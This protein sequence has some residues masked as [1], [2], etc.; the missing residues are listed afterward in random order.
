[1]SIAI[2]D[3][4]YSVDGVSLL[5]NISLEVESG[6]IVAIVGPNGSGKSSLLKAA[7]GE[8]A[9]Q[10][11]MVEIHG[12]SIASMHLAERALGFGVLPQE[13]NL[14]FPFTVEEVVQMGRIPHLA[15]MYENKVILEDVLKEMELQDIRD[16]IY[17]TLSGGEKQRVQ[18]GRVFCQI[19]GA[20]E[21]ACL[22]LDEPTA[23]LDLA[24]QIAL[25]K[26]IRKVAKLGATVMVV[27]HDI[28]LALRFAE[29]VV[30]LESGRVLSSGPPLEVFSAE[31]M[32]AA[33]DVEVEIFTTDD[34]MRP[35]LIARE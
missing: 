5:R 17:P 6:S 20:R 9:I 10:Q 30:L 22:F 29:H 25:F 18:I 1:M 27:L 35:F 14:D 31:N 11:G 24:H 21:D 28:N 12:K 16:R 15:S 23:A 2:S 33:F 26:S 32:N 8:V 4:F 13:A 3:L 34:P 19:W 7:C